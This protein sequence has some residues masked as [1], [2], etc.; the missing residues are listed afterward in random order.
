MHFYSYSLVWTTL[1]T[2]GVIICDSGATFGFDADVFVAAE[3]AI[4]A[5]AANPRCLGSVKNPELAQAVNP[6]IKDEP[7]PI[8]DFQSNLIMFFTYVV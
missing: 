6:A 4:A 5:V 7:A 3:L 2:Y 8:G 1:F